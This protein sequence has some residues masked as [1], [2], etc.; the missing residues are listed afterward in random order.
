MKKLIV[1]ALIVFTSCKKE[2]LK[3]SKEQKPITF[4]LEAVSKEN[5]IIDVSQTF[6]F[7]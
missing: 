4:Y 5:D 1:I 6:Y 3:Q 7:K 2:L